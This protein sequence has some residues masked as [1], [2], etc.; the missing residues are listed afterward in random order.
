MV[1]KEKSIETIETEC[2][3]RMIRD[4]FKAPLPTLI[5]LFWLKTE[6]EGVLRHSIARMSKAGSMGFILE[7]RN[8]PLYLSEEWWRLVGICLDEAKQR[9]MKLWLWDEKFFPSGTAGGRVTQKSTDYNQKIIKEK[10]IDISDCKN[11]RLPISEIA[12]EPEDKLFAI[13]ACKQNP[14]G[15]MQIDDLVGLEPCN[16]ILERDMPEGE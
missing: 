2:N 12:D 4:H 9:N 13:F 14:S 1:N 6:D 3:E 5:P 8:N 7:N 10:I 11:T 16:G 15:I